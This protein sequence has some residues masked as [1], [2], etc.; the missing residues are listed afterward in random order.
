MS[1]RR[2]L[3]L[4]KLANA[5]R[6]IAKQHFE[7]RSKQLDAFSKT[8]TLAKTAKSQTDRVT[9]TVQA[10]AALAKRLN[11]E[12]PK[13]AE[14]FSA[15]NAWGNRQGTVPRESAGSE[16]ERQFERRDAA[17]QHS[18]QEELDIRQAKAAR[19]PLPDGTIPPKNA[20]VGHPS[21][22]NDTYTNR[23]K[24]EPVKRPLQE[25]RKGTDEIRPA[26]S[27]AS[28]IP[29]PKAAQYTT[30]DARKLQRISESQI[31]S[32][33]AAASTPK[34]EDYDRD[35]YSDRSTGENTAYSSLPRAK[36]PKRTEGMQQESL[37]WRSINSDVF[38]ARPVH[39]KSASA[40]LQ[41]VPE[42]VDVNVFR[43]SKVSD[44]LG[45]RKA[46]D[47]QPSRIR[48]PRLQSEVASAIH[49][50][51]RDPRDSSH[52]PVMNAESTK[53]TSTSTPNN[54]SEYGRR[55]LAEDMAKDAAQH[56]T[57]NVEVSRCLSL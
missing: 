43:S 41:E 2:L 45:V 15:Q 6:N 47:T 54:R 13:Y 18:A 56:A 10:A 26:E 17:L 42:G 14:S 7:L 44:M 46:K 37:D 20:P 5:S 3:D 23:P 36:I 35:V 30:E 40:D 34:G 55:D 19:D 11:E 38:H 50:A 52:V 25:Q 16:E 21:A 48:L 28:T 31:P 12:T 57:S 8:S 29:I 4:A 33:T 1:G 53:C 49:P 22:G 27:E 9:L 51:L 24:P 32:V 39:Q